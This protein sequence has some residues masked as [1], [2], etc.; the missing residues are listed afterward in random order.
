[1]PGKSTV[2]HA[3]LSTKEIEG[4]LAISNLIPAN[5]VAGLDKLLVEAVTASAELLHLDNMALFLQDRVRKSLLL[6]IVVHH[7]SADMPGE[8]IQATDNPLFSRIAGATGPVLLRNPSTRSEKEL[9]RY[10]SWQGDPLVC[11]PIMVGNRKIGN[12]SF[13][14]SVES[15]DQCGKELFLLGI[16]A[17]RIGILLENSRISR[18]KQRKIEELATLNQIGQYINASLDIDELLDIIY[19]QAS[20]ILDTTNFFI[21]LYDKNTQTLNVK[22]EYEGGT[23]RN[24]IVL[25]LGEGLSSY[26]IKTQKPLL[27]EN[28][29]PEKCRELGIPHLGKPAKSWLGVPM[30]HNGRIHGVITVQNYERYNA[31][32]GEDLDILTAIANQASIAIQNSRFVEEVS[33]LKEFS[34]NVI[35]SIPSAITVINASGEIVFVNRQFY[36]YFDADEA[37]TLFQPLNEVLPDSVIQSMRRTSQIESFLK[38]EGNNYPAHHFTQPWTVESDGR[39]FSVRASRILESRKTEDQ[40]FLLIIDDIS[41]RKNLEKLILESKAKLQAIFDGITDGIMVV[42]REYRIVSINKALARFLETPI[43]ELIGKKCCD[44]FTQSNPQFCEKCAAQRVFETGQIFSRPHERVKFHDNQFEMNITVFPLFDDQKRVVQ[45]IV[46]FRD[47]TREKEIEERLIE[48]EK[49]VALGEMA[50]EIGHE[51]KNYLQAISLS[52]E[53]IP[54]YIKGG[55]HSKIEHYARL[56]L[57]NMD[58]MT[59]LTNGLMDFSSHRVKKEVSDV[60]HLIDATIR[61]V[62]PQNLFDNI[63]FST[64]CMTDNTTITVD[65]GQFQQVLLNLFRNA[66]QAIGSVKKQQGA[67]DI[68]V[69]DD[70]LERS[71]MIISV[72]DNGPG[73]PRNL[74]KKIFEPKYTNKENGHGLGLSI[75]YRIIANHRGW[76]RAESEYGKGTVFHIGLPRNY[77]H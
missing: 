52:A 2:S 38:G 44:V 45:R 35:K 24:N 66:G 55:N 41:D 47:I 31:Y 77:E 39:V 68:A 15:I 75:C 60:M 32:D 62:K 76:I 69:K 14:K 43:T 33:R 54:V 4:F 73:I 12:I 27:I 29:A 13:E 51:L 30:V 18:E 58:K 10:L 21:A 53:M 71:M 34:D 36:R 46:Y 8:W 28:G 9:S 6:K 25:K 16:V 26:C 65:T 70:P 59:S 49:M 11:I 61:F 7:G 20:C 48:S 3:Q 57:D 64:S 40:L 5:P 37:H 1:M 63:E 72:A 23:K 17:S 56:I 19:I 42:D 22:L 67:I 50:Y 74:I